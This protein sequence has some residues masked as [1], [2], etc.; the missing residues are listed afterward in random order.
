MVSLLWRFLS[1]NRAFIAS[2]TPSDNWRPWKAAHHWELQNATFRSERKTENQNQANNCSY[3]L[4][5]PNPE[6]IPALSKVASFSG[7]VL[8]KDNLFAWFLFS[9]FILSK[10]ILDCCSFQQ[11]HSQRPLVVWS[12]SDDV[13][14]TK[15]Q[16][17]KF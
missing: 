9:L 13:T 4:R 8:L 15:P 1:W 16:L 7:L 2:D 6:N 14:A 11:H 12:S 10:Q 5:S 17:V 3:S